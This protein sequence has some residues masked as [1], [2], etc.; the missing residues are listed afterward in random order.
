MFPIEKNNGRQRY[1]F[2]RFHRKPLANT[3]LLEMLE[4]TMRILANFT[5]IKQR[6]I[7]YLD[8]GAGIL[9]HRNYLK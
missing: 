8:E 7:E 5:L 4:V 3:R 1:C 9:K 6:G 2:A